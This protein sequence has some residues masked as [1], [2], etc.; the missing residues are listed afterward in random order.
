MRWRVGAL[1]IPLTLVG[2]AAAAQ[3]PASLP[4]S[5]DSLGANSTPPPR[6]VT[7]PG[8][9]ALSIDG[10]FE[11]GGFVFRDGYPFLHNDGGPTWGNTALG[12]DALVSTTPGFPYNFNGRDNTAIGLGALGNNTTGYNNTATGMDALR[13]N[14]EGGDNTAVGV[15]ALRY[16]TL[17]IWNTATGVRAMEFSSGVGDFPSGGFNTAIGVEALQNNS[18]GYRNTATGVWALEANETGSDNTATGMGALR[19]NT[20]GDQNTAAGY[21]A[22]RNNTEG[23]RNIGLGYGAG[24][25]N[26]TGTDNVWIMHFGDESGTEANTLRIGEDTGTGY[27]ELNRA[28]VSGIQNA[29]LTGA[30]QDVCV[31]VEDQLGPCSLSSRRFKEEIRELGDASAGLLALRPVL[32]SYKAEVKEGHAAE[33]FGLIAEEVAEVFPQ[34]VSTDKDGRPFTVRYDLLTPLL[35]NELQ[36]QHRR[37]EIQGWLMGLMFLATVALTVG[38]WRSG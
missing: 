22:L 25:N 15:F 28:F 34:L 6:T 36:K 14:T 21:Q 23:S 20:S 8:S 3:G 38:R 4:L 2:L 12:L 7:P 17:G 31:D 16:N 33:H 5:S 35:L 18:A 1:A 9:Y 26:N 10:D 32:F 27:W 19:L 30:E 13:H 11:L 24:S 29:V 37:V